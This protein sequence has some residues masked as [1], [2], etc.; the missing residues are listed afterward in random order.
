MCIARYCMWRLQLTSDVFGTCGRVIQDSFL[1]FLY[2]NS[3][4]YQVFFWHCQGP[5][6]VFF[7]YPFFSLFRLGVPL[8]LIL[9]KNPCSERYATTIFRTTSL[10]LS[11]SSPFRLRINSNIPSGRL[12]RIVFIQPTPLFV[13]G[14]CYLLDLVMLYILSISSKLYLAYSFFVSFNG[15]L[16]ESWRLN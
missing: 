3:C 4:I 14:L 1:D 5:G 8:M 15:V 11:P 6:S 12:T 16:K 7:L 9:L 13:L 10:L 2:R